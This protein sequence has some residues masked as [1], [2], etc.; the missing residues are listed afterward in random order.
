MNRKDFQQIIS[1]T[2]LK[3][4]VDQKTRTNNVTIELSDFT[5]QFSYLMPVIE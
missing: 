4:I 1:T 3:P 5:I 2:R